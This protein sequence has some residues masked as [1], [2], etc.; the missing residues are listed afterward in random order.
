MVK[1]K[2]LSYIGYIDILMTLL[3]RYICCCGGAQARFLSMA[4]PLQHIITDTC[5]PWRCK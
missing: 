2:E 5:M 3:R 1:L 4:V